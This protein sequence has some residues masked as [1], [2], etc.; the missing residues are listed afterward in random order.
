MK[1][2]SK[3]VQGV[4]AA[5]KPTHKDWPLVVYVWI[6]GLGFTGYLVARIARDAQP[7]PVHWAAGLAGAIAGYG[8][9]WLWYRWRGDIL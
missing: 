5:P 6:A 3:H 9:G 7:H 1:T 8:A 2:V 4:N